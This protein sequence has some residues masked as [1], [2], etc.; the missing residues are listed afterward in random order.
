MRNYDLLCSRIQSRYNP[1]KRRISLPAGTSAKYV[2][3]VSYALD[4]HCQVEKANIVPPCM[5]KT[6]SNW[7]DQTEPLNRLKWIYENSLSSR[8]SRQIF[9]LTAGKVSNVNEQLRKALKSYITVV[10]VKLT[11][12][13]ANDRIVVYTLA[14]GL[15]I[16]RSK[17]HTN[18][19]VKMS[20]ILHSKNNPTTASDD[21]RVTLIRESSIIEHRVKV[22]FLLSDTLLTILLGII[23][24]LFILII[25]LTILYARQ[26][27]QTIIKHTS[28]VHSTSTTSVEDST[29]TTLVRPPQIIQ[30]AAFSKAVHI[31]EGFVAAADD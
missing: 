21:T 5:L 30:E 4:F 24:L 22:P 27:V 12:F 18:A 3:S 9:L 7:H 16:W 19:V 23:A 25:F 8:H 17:T 13:Y 26:N 31:E 10:K 6:K 20:K 11:P 15:A 14:N 2:Q 1:L 29:S 28:A